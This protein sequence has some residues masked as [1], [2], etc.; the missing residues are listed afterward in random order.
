MITLCNALYSNVILPRF[1]KSKSTAV[2]DLINDK[3]V[4]EILLVKMVDTDYW[5]F[6]QVSSYYGNR[7]I[8]TIVIIVTMV[9][10]VTMVTIV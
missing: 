3:P 8:V 10:M 9:T 1:S 4:C 7:G 2:I 6:P 5:V